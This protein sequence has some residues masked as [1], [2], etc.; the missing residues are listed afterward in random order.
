M[1]RR[2][3]L[4]RF[5]EVRRTLRGLPKA[6]Q[7]ELLAEF[8]A[9]G[10]KI[11]TEQRLRAPKKTH[12]LEKGID[13][14]VFPNTLRLEVGLRNLKKGRADLFYGRIQ[15]LGRRAQTV[16]VQRL[17]KGGRAKWTGRIAAGK[18]RAG[19]KPRDLVASYS[20]RVRGME[21]KKFVT[22]KFPDLRKEARSSLQGIYAR[23]IG[24]AGSDV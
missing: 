10:A 1:A 6:V 11:A 2:R 17:V 13:H 14:K 4:R 20:M 5:P 21:G 24:K 22:G 19:A 12:A 15:D 23:A 8:E 18:A 16:I 3:G 7:N 9:I